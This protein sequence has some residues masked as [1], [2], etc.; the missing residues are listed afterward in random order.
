MPLNYAERFLFE[1]SLH[2]PTL[3]RCVVR[4]G[5]QGSLDRR[6]ANR[7]RRLFISNGILLY[8]KFEKFPKEMQHRILATFSLNKIKQKD[9]M[10]LIRELYGYRLTKNGKIYYQ[11]GFVEKYSGVKISSNAILIPV[12]KTK[13]LREIL[14]KFKITPQIRE[15]WER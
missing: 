6:T 1:Q 11:K 2:H 12:E 9:K 15:I 10:K 7:R 13:E 5:R 3:F 8:G 14:S 4:P